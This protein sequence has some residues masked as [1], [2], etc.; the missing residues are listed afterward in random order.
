MKAQKN[1]PECDG[2]NLYSQTDISVR[3]GYGPDLLPGAGAFFSSAKA[4]AI[5][6][7]DCGFIRYFASQDA[8]RKISGSDKWKRVL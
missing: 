2:V 5:V 6:C 4:T 7:A 1:C 3:G 8:R